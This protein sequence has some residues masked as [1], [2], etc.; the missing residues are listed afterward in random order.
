MNLA[1]YMDWIRD[2]PL[3]S[4]RQYETFI[5]HVLRVHSW[6][7]TSLRYGIECVVF[8]DPNVGGELAGQQV[9]DLTWYGGPDNRQYR[10]TYGCLAYQWRRRGPTFAGPGIPKHREYRSDYYMDT[11]VAGQLAKRKDYPNPDLPREIIQQC[12]FVIYPYVNPK[13]FLQVAYFLHIEELRAIWAGRPHPGRRALALLSER[14]LNE[15]DGF[16]FETEYKP[17]W[18]AIG[19]RYFDH[20]GDSALSGMPLYIRGVE[21]RASRN[22]WVPPQ[23]HPL[24]WA[25][26]LDQLTTRQRACARHLWYRF[27]R[28]ACLRRSEFLKVDIA[29]ENLRRLVHRPVCEDDRCR[30]VLRSAPGS[31]PYRGVP[32]AV[33]LV[34]GRRAPLSGDIPAWWRV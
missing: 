32:E 31:T 18:E 10:E 15:N 3:P 4:E 29:L 28:L 11:V 5:F 16:D 30:G 12:S 9:G 8:L 6:Y 33:C 7:K 21:A 22:Y 23:H 19:A 13:E 24:R 27:R 17:V 25:M 2:A 34:C 26:G 20:S 14:D 1:E